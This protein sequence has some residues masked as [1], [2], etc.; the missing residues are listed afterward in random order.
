MLNYDIGKYGESIAIDYLKSNGYRILNMNFR[1]KLGEIDII[2]LYNDIIVFTEVKSRFSRN[3][4]NPC[5]CVNYKKQKRIITT[6][7]YYISKNSR[8]NYFFRFD[9]IEVFFNTKKDTYNINHITDAFR[10][11]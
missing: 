10:L 2:S 11:N 5:D 6:A 9:V 3:Y 8:H 7:E 1:C 4:G